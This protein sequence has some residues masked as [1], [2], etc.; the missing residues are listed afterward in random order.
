M[1]QHR[2][3]GRT[4]LAAALAT[5]AIV[6][7]GGCD[8]GPA[9]NAEAPANEA[10]IPA[11]EAV[12][13]DGPAPWSASATTRTADAGVPDSGTPDSTAPHQRRPESG[14]STGLTSVT[15]DGR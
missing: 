15:S 12:P 4:G 6:L 9:N 8:L 5:A 14:A 7:L 11:V 13:I 2:P 3:W 10:A 1:K